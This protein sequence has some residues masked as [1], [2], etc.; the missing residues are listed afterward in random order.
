MYLLLYA[1]YLLYSLALVSARF[2]REFPLRSLPALAL[3]SLAILLLGLFAI[4]WQQILKKMPL[5]IAYA[6]RVITILY[7]FVFSVILFSE[8]IG[9]TM[10]LGAG[11]IVCGVI[12][13]SSGEPKAKPDNEGGNSITSPPDEVRP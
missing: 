4:F 12:L 7:G 11:I 6:H 2:A 5:T 8:E 10:F 3:Y 9:F 13:M 1:N